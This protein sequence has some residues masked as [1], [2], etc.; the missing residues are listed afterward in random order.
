MFASTRLFAGNRLPEAIGGV[1]RDIDHPHPG[2]YADANEPHGWSTSSVILALQALLGL[3]PVAP[4]GLLLVNP[5]LPPWL[6]DLT[7]RG[8]RVG[9]SRLDLEFRRGRAGGTRF[10]ATV[11][12]GRI[13]VL[14]Q[15][16]ELSPRTTALARA[17]AATSSLRCQ[18]RAGASDD[19]GP[20]PA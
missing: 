20:Q 5:Q 1:P 15:P 2:I 18:R 10:R 6:P 8:V 12:S 17:L 7:L 11:L 4:L 9:G 13:R 19:P 16:A 3:R 14:R